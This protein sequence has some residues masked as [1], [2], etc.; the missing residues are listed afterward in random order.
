[1]RLGVG[2]PILGRQIKA[3]EQELG[4]ELYHRTGRGI[5]LC[6]AGKILDLHAR[7]VLET[8][9]GARRAINTLGSEPASS[10]VIGMPP[11]VGAV[12]TAPLVRQFRDEFPRASLRVG[13]FDFQSFGS[14][15]SRTIQSSMP[16]RAAG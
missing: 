6:E 1:M 14:A 9:A 10:V 16:A 15:S 2:Q 7:G 8:T 13:G 12:L 3:L 11:S 5:V 4:T